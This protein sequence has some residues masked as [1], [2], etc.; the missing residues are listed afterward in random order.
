VPVFPLFGPLMSV[1]VTVAPLT[2]LPL[3][4]TVAVSVWLVPVAALPLGPASPT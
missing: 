1:K 4:W 3:T 2:A